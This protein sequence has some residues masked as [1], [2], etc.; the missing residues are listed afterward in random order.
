MMNS[1]CSAEL[2]PIYIK[3]SYKPNQSCMQINQKNIK[4]SQ[5]NGKSSDT[6]IICCLSLLFIYPL[7]K[8]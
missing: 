7:K 3:L 5:L 2:Y 6:K 4:K 8:N 1:Y